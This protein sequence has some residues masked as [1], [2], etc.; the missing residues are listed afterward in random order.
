MAEPN[1]NI[2]TLSNIVPICQLKR[3]TR[4]PRP[5][6][7]QLEYYASELTY[8]VEMDLEVKESRDEM[9]AWIY[10]FETDPDLQRMFAGKPVQFVEFPGKPI[11]KPAEFVKMSDLPNPF[12]GI[13]RSE[14][15]ELPPTSVNIEKGWQY[16]TILEVK[17]FCMQKIKNLIKQ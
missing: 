10:D 7:E 9:K 15:S 3:Q 13:K 12:E 1:N 16:M 2:N 8:H 17:K 14:E 4:R 11:E 5:N 6:M